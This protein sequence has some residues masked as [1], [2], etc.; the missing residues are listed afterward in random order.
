MTREYPEH[1]LPGVAAV[2]RRGDQVLLVRRGREPAKGAWALPGGLLELGESVEEGLRREL[3]EECG[4]E[5]QVGP[6]IAVFEPVER[7]Q[8]GRVRF[9][10]VVLDYLADYLSGELQAADDAADAHWVHIAALDDLPMLPETRAIIRRA[11]S[12]DP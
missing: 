4:I 11:L 9:H 7:D 8:V 1:P 10:F 6:L 5:V 3:R 2:V 12:V